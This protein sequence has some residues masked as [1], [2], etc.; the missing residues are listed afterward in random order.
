[1]LVDIG[2]VEVGDLPVVNGVLNYRSIQMWVQ[3]AGFAINVFLQCAAI[4]K[5]FG[6]R[7]GEDKSSRTFPLGLDHQVKKLL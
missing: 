4:Q 2:Y 3:Q 7:L 1:M 6:S 5:I